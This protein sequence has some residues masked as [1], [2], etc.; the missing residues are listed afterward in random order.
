MTK[1]KKFARLLNLQNRLSKKRIFPEEGGPKSEA[2]LAYM[3]RPCLKDHQ[4]QK[5][6]SR[7]T[8]VLCLERSN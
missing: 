2:S 7:A 5:E 6:L 3:M 1:G 8:Q 4:Q